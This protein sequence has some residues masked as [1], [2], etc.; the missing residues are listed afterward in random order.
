MSKMTKRRETEMRLIIMPI[1][2]HFFLSFLFASTLKRSFHSDNKNNVSLKDFDR[3]LFF[4][5]FNQQ[6]KARYEHKILDNLAR[7]RKFYSFYTRLLV[8]ATRNVH[9]GHLLKKL[10][11]ISK[12]YDEIFACWIKL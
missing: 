10:Y 6:K 5:N 8:T 4:Y 11:L 2:I 1:L 7:V 12:N 9:L 3:L